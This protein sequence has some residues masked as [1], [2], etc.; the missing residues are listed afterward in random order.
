MLFLFA[1]IK[2][3]QSVG[4]PKGFPNTLRKEAV[5]Y[6]FFSFHIVQTHEFFQKL[7]GVYIRKTLLTQADLL[8]LSSFLINIETSLHQISRLSSCLKH[9]G[10]PLVLLYEKHSLLLAVM[11]KRVQKKLRKIK[12]KLKNMLLL[13]FA[14]YSPFSNTHIDNT[15]NKIHP[16]KR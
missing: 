4:N 9:I 13:K 5:H 3:F 14:A 7:V 1:K 10:L 16:Y 11:Q 2:R 15:T 8:G 12:V 6:C